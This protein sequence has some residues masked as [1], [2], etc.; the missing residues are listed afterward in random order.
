MV[1]L[2]LLQPLSLPQ[3]LTLADDVNAI[4]GIPRHN[5]VHRLQ[6]FRVAHEDMT[7][8]H[9]HTVHIQHP[10]AVRFA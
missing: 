1:W 6:A 8:L 4:A 3:V 9:A 7:V 2:E 10:L 5:V